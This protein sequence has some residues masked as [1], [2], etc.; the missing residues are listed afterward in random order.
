MGGAPAPAPMG[1]ASDVPPMGDMGPTGPEGDPAGAPD[2][3]MDGMNDGNGQLDPN[4]D[5]MGGEPPMDGGP[6]AGGEEG[7]DDDSTESIIRQLN[8]KDKET[9]R[10]YAESLLS[11]EEENDGENM[12]GEEQPMDGG[13]MGQDPSA[14]PMMESVVFTKSQLKKIHEGFK[15][16]ID[17]DENK[18][19]NKMRNK[20][21]VKNSPFKSPKFD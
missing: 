14:A 13:D 1:G 6:M 19:N 18:G 2:A 9:V 10:A 21:L 7:G 8:D 5:P 20:N 16:N 12:D 4:M 11:T 17:N 3:G 15:R